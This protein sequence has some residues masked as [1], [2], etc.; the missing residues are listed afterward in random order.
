[1]ST[2]IR[3]VYFNLTVQGVVDIMLLLVEVGGFQKCHPPSCMSKQQ[4]L[5]HRGNIAYVY[6]STCGAER[7]WGIWRNSNSTYLLSLDAHAK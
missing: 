2:T 4:T 1:M 3:F 6:M 7:T 5:A